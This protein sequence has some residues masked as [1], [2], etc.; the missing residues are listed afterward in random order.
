MIKKAAVLIV[1]LVTSIGAFS[2]TAFGLKGGLNL[3]TI[4]WND[5]QATYNGRSGYHAGI[6]LRSRHEKIAFQP[7]V[8]LYTQKGDL[9]SSV[10]GT[11]QES[12]T[13]V[14][15]PVLFKFY[16]VGGLNLHA[17]PQFGFLVDGERKYDT[18]FGGGSEDITESYK[19]SD[20]AVS[21]GLGYDFKF[22][23]SVDARYNIGVKDINN[24]ANGDDAKSRVFM[25]SLGWNFLK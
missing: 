1:L 4:N 20:V 16:P 23:L 13:Y 5:A 2:Q 22:G 11:A 18:V 12:F 14:T 3:S 8:L 25:I 9:Q 19:K 24:A 10:F 7:E 21:A 17:G 15:V 6:F